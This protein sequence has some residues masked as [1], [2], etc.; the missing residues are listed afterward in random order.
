MNLLDKYSIDVDSTVSKLM[1][2]FM[3][4]KKMHDFLIGV[5]TPIMSVYLS[6]KTWAFEK[7]TEANITSQHIVINWGL[8]NFFKQYFIEPDA[9]IYLGVWLD[10]YASIYNT[11]EVK[12]DLFPYDYVFNYEERNSDTLVISN[13]SEINTVNTNYDFYVFVPE[14][15]EN[16]I[17]YAKY[18]E[19]IQT[20]IN[21][22]AIKR[23]K[24]KIIKKYER[25][26]NKSW[27]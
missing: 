26:S 11:D 23:L 2:W 7:I 16:K 5:A 22:Y 1:P 6:F 15:N 12:N 21:K 10:D 9:N 25:I 18:V 24:Y 13:N 4:G 27:R 19:Q 17:S 20:L 14:I 8:N 3:R